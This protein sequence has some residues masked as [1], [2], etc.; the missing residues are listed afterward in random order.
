MQRQHGPL[1]TR[2]AG[3]DRGRQS[4]RPQ[5]SARQPT[6]RSKEPHL[7]TRRPAWLG[8]ALTAEPKHRA[9]GQSRPWPCAE[10]R[11]ADCLLWA[12]RPRHL[13]RAQNV[14]AHVRRETPPRLSFLD[15]H[16]LSVDV[17]ALSYEHFHDACEL[18][19]LLIQ[20]RDVQ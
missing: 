12:Y 14:L 1:P 20:S 19:S 4:A 8:Q 15:R 17:H 16:L 10:R 2:A 18:I 7:L 5:E 6:S 13:G 9:T 3:H 11:S